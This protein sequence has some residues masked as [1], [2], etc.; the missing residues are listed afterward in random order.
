MHDTLLHLRSGSKRELAR[1]NARSAGPEKYADALGAVAF[2]GALDGAGKS[3]LLD[4]E[5]RETIVAAIPRCEGLRQCMR[6]QTVD[7]AD[8]GFERCR[9]LEIVAAQ[10]APRFVQRAPHFAPADAAGIGQRRS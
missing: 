8:A 6:F 4:R 1:Q 5:M 7:S 3:I 2:A 9:R 10:A